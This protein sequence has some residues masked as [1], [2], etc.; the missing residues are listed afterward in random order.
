[1]GR[2]VA[3]TSFETRPQNRLKQAQ[4]TI[5]GTTYTDRYEYDGEGRRETRETRG[6]HGDGNTG[7]N[8]G[9]HETRETRGNTGNT[10]IGTCEEIDIST[11]SRSPAEQ[12]CGDTLLST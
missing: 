11:Q 9:K 3:L 7:R 12:H 4:T 8:T 2:V 1:M 10:G 6:K 5:N